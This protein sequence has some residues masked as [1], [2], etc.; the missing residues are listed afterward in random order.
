MK[1]IKIFAVAGAIG[2]LCMA[3]LSSCKQNNTPEETG[4]YNGETVKTEFVISIADN[5]IGSGD[6]RR[7]PGATVQI[8]QNRASF[9]GMDSICLIPFDG[10]YTTRIGKNIALSP[11]PAT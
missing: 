2:L 6:V 5:V 3:G 11:I 4:N 7:M 10:N 1:S 8:D 9:R